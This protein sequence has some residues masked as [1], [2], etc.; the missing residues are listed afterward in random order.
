L[1][2]RSRL[3]LE[4]IEA[5]AFDRNVYA[6]VYHPGT[7]DSAAAEPI[8]LRAGATVAGID[9]TL[10][11]AREVHIRGQ[12]VV[13]DGRSASRA[14]SLALTS[15]DFP[16]AL[17]GVTLDPD[18]TGSFDFPHVAPGHYFVSAQTTDSGTRLWDAV[19]VDVTDQEPPPVTIAPK[20][21]V[22]VTGRLTVD[23]DAPPSG[24]PP[25]LV[26]LQGSCCRGSLPGGRPVGADGTFTFENLPARDYRLLVV[27]AGASP[28]VKSARFGGADVTGGSIRI[29]S[30]S[31]GREL[32]IDLS[33]RTAA[34][35]AM[36]V[37]SGERAAPGVLVVAVPSVDRRGD[38]H[39][40]RTATTG[41]DGH[42]RVDG[43]APGDYTLFAS[44]SI[45]AAD[46]QDPAVLQHV[47]G[48]GTAATFREGETRTVTLRITP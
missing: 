10:T 39:A 23:G 1:T 22:T 20:A 47:E 45:A 17:P 16:S 44:D 8:D 21:G 33:T 18:A 43:L 4:T 29:G 30:D 25:I 34:L 36:V 12:V 42:A 19:R 2:E 35:D 40:Y 5:A 26:M 24:R 14:I 46:W 15:A 13:G 31:K 27:Q 28:F 37:G 9:L 41:A 7:T 11:P 38:Y 32:E 48:R 3:T 6:P